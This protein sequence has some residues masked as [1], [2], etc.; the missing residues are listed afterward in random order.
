MELKR[1]VQGG[2]FLKFVTCHPA[3]LKLDVEEQ[4]RDRFF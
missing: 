3:L 4:N 1:R 2:G